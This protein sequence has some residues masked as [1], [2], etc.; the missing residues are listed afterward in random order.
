MLELGPKNYLE[1]ARLLV[2]AGANVNHQ[3]G[4][5]RRSATGNRSTAGVLDI[6]LKHALFRRYFDLADYLISAGADVN[7]ITAEGHRLID[8]FRNVNNPEAVRYLTY[9]GA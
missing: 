9:K 2:E 3:I 1:I 6:P 4:G 5:I 7:A 8:F